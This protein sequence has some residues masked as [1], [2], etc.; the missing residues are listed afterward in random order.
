MLEKTDAI[1]ADAATKI[2]KKAAVE[3]GFSDL[4]RANHLFGR[5]V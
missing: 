2:D 4:L 1:G 5:C 3:V